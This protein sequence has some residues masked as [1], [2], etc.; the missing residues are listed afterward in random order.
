MS[1]ENSSL[2][3]E[4]CRQSEGSGHTTRKMGITDKKFVA[5]ATSLQFA[6]NFAANSLVVKICGREAK[7]CGEYCGKLLVETFCS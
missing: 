5:D 7:V 4:D 6:E 3:C 1:F 2:G